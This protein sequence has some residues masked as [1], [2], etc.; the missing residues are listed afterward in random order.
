MSPNGI[1][2]RP[3]AVG[4]R[5]RQSRRGYVRLLRVGNLLRVASVPHSAVRRTFVLC[6]LFAISMTGCS[7]VLG[8]ADASYRVPIRLL[9]HD[10]IEWPR[11]QTSTLRYALA[12]VPGTLFGVADRA[13]L[14]QMTAERAHLGLD[15]ADLTAWAAKAAQPWRAANAEVL[16]VQP[17]DTRVA[18]V[19]LAA[20]ASSGGSAYGVGFHDLLLRRNLVL[21]YVDRGCT[22]TTPEVTADLAAGSVRYDLK[23]PR[24][25]WYWL[26]TGPGEAIEDVDLGSLSIELRPRS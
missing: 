11:D 19:M 2:A 16:D 4:S 5:R 1:A 26:R 3:G 18:R 25:G 13:T 12:I 6:A 10:G 7:G 24:E 14:R 15:M 9:D 8:G 20:F 22:V 21:I 23:L 17:V